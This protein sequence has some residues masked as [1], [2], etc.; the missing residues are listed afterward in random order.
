MFFFK[1]RKNENL[2]PSE[3]SETITFFD[4]EINRFADCFQHVRCFL[5]SVKDTN[6]FRK[7]HI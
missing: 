7:Y 4:V 5:K 1:G 6:F 2:F 3:R